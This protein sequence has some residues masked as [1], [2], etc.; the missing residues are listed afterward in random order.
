MNRVILSTDSNKDYLQ[1]WPLTALAWKKLGFQ[2]TLGIVGDIDINENLGDVYK[3]NRVD[4][5]S[6]MFNAKII[7]LYLPCLFPDDLCIL[8][9]IDLNR[10]LTSQNSE[11]EDT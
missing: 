8:G 5:V 3:F 7:R 2:P 4:G 1:F 9:D 11:R 10:K 6:S